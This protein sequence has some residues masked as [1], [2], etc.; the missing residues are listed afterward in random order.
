V[1]NVFFIL[2]LL[3]Y[4]YNLIVRVTKKLGEGGQGSVF[5]VIDQDSN[6][7]YAIKRISVEKGNEDIMHEIRM[8]LNKKLQHINLV[9]YLTF[10]HEGE[11]INIVMELCE[12]GNLEDYL[13][14]NENNI[15]PEKVF[16][17]FNQIKIIYLYKKH[18][19]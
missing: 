7:K 1:E 9:G 5:A 16:I 10:F 13:K 14:K 3:F 8:L 15:I 2:F 18:S 4:F 12:E 17:F 11:F 6:E 19:K